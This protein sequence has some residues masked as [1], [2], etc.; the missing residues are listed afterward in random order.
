MYLP[1]E[2]AV[3]AP[4][5]V[6]GFG[7]SRATSA[8]LRAIESRGWRRSVLLGRA[9]LAV[10]NGWVPFFAV[11]HSRSWGN[12]WQKSYAALCDAIRDVAP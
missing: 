3:L 12:M 5:A 7:I 6:I 1:D 9:E 2:L 10:S 8:V 11:H 4:R